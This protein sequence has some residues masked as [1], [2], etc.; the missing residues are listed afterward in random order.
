MAN[1]D[2]ALRERLGGRWAISLRAYLISFPISV[3]LGLLATP[4]STESWHNFGVWFVVSVLAFV[5]SGLVLLIADRTVMK[6]R[7][8]KPVP[9]WL[10]YV[11]DIV[12]VEIRTWVYVICIDQFQLSNSTSTPVR[13]LG[14]F[15]LALVWYPALTYALDSWDR[16]ATL[17]NELI[18]ELV[19]D[20]LE[21]LKQE[22]VLEVLRVGLISDISAQV[23]KSVQDAATTLA[24]LQDAVAK[25]TVANK[26][27]LS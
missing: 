3:S 26:R 14:G 2:V 8:T 7:R 5:I 21:I 25:N 13:F 27:S 22:Q 12:S 4:E 16:Y 19:K 11:V 1:R 6:G 20:E 24:S 9:V 23:N 17:R 18:S 15:L 10:V